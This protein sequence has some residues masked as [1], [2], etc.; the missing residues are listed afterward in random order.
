MFWFIIIFVS[1]GLF[2]PRN[3]TAIAMIFL[4]AIGIG[5]A[6]RLMTAFMLCTCDFLLVLFH[7]HEGKRKLLAGR[8]RSQFGIGRMPRTPELV[9]SDAPRQ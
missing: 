3:M 1:F 5:T 4:C 7:Q 8:P 9:F 2:A 6:I